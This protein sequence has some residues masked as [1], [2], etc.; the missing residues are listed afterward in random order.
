MPVLDSGTERLSP[1]LALIA[2]LGLMVIPAEATQSASDLS[3]SLTPGTAI[4]DDHAQQFS[5]RGDVA[6]NAGNTLSASS[7]VISDVVVYYNDATATAYLIVVDGAEALTSAGAVAPT[8][9]EVVAAL[10]DSSYT[11]ARCGRVKFSRDAGTAITIDYI[12]HTVRP[13]GVDPDA[14]IAVTSE[15]DVIGDAELYEFHHTEGIEVDA[16]DIAAADILT[17]KPVPPFHGKIGALRAVVTKAIT[18]GAKAATINAEIGTTNLT[19]GTVALAGAY[20]LGAIQAQGAAPSAGNTFKP[21]DTWSLEGSAVT[22]FIEGR[23]RI[24][25][26]FYK[27]RTV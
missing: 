14:K 11:Y 22:P 26:D 1:S 15:T 24:E 2:L 3:V 16:A 25:A 19:G 27:L 18:T 21:G 8:D 4:L 13:L 7:E 20:A 6:I 5:G 9:A 17:N 23:V 12:D 10:P